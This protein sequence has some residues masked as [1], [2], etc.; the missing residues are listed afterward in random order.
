MFKLNYA[1]HKECTFTI[2]FPLLSDFDLL[3]TQPFVQVHIKE[4]SKLRG[5][6]QGPVNS[7][8]KGPVTRKCLHLMTSSWIKSIAFGKCNC[9]FENSII[10][11]D[12]KSIGMP[13][14]DKPL[15]EPIL[16]KFL[17]SI[18]H[19][20]GHMNFM[21]FNW[22][23]WNKSYEYGIPVIRNASENLHR[24]SYL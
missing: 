18:W 6:H 12:D 5:I 23:V 17:D 1:V 2:P 10:L 16:W 7:P 20:Q 14:G 13:T 21:K 3:F 22:I 9:I 15:P 24:I 19:D 11:T 4:T 8:H